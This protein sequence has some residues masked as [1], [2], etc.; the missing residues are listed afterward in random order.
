MELNHV[1]LDAYL[2]SGRDCRGSVWIWRDSGSFGWNRQ[3][4]VLYL[5]HPLYCFA[6]GRADAESL[7]IRRTGIFTCELDAWINVNKYWK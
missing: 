1:A 2:P 7:G 3:N 4:S 6:V 5:P